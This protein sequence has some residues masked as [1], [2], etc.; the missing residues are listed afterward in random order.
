MNKEVYDGIICNNQIS[1]RRISIYGAT[2]ESIFKG[3]S[4]KI[5]KY[6]DSVLNAQPNV[7]EYILDKNQYTNNI[8]KE[9]K[10]PSNAWTAAYVTGKKYRF[11]FGQT[12]LNFEDLK[13]EVSERWEE[14]DKDIEFFHNFSDVR[15]AINV[16]IDGVQIPNN[17][18]S[19]TPS[20]RQCGQNFV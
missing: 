20:L 6:D 10:K 16:T 13:I 19:S 2:K 14:W 4:Q 3:M 11:H 12:G 17:S 8:M 5:L 9:K 1:V 15:V 18:I 7:T